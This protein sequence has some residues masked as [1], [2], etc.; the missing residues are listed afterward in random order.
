[1]G[2]KPVLVASAL[3]FLAFTIACGFAQSSA[4][5]IVFRVLAGF[6]G[7]A[8]L[9]IGAALI[10]DMYAP[11]ER[12]TAMG[13]YMALQLGGPA[14][15]DSAPYPDGSE[16]RA[17][18]FSEQIGPIV[19]GWIA[20]TIDSWR[21]TFY[22]C[23][24]ATAVVLAFGTF[25]LPET[26]APKLNSHSRPPVSHVFRTLGRPFLMLGTQPIIQVLA[27]YAAIIFGIYYIFLTTIVSVFRDDYGHSVGIASLH[28]IALL[29]GFIS[30]VAASSTA[31]DALYRR[32]SRNGP[33]PEARLPYLGAS[34]TL[35]PIGLLIYG[36]TA[37]YKVFWLVP[38][39]GLFLVGL[40]ILAP[41][42]AIQHYLLDCY[43]SSGC[44][45]SALA[46]MNVARFLAGF[47][48]PLFADYLYDALGLGWGDS[49]LALI[50]AVTGCLSLSL[51]QFGP[52]LR[53]MSSWTQA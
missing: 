5:L 4:Q 21:W 27:A 3:L 16:S 10:G 19:G 39:I 42:A 17:D 53:E 31:M 45:A 37:E 47:G 46:G 14:V 44:T 33:S 50:A 11:E 30:S 28:Y 41:L 26:Y 8:P 12:G 2:R 43:S 7:C 51:W 9:A 1:M 29:L 52:R 38:D 32:L 40:G 36:W 24:I 18:A 13:I 34:G 20:Q 49:L 35:L 25:I 48:F 6:G 22:I 23:A 15:S